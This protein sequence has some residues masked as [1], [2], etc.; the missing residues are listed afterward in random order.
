MK[1]ILLVDFPLFTFRMFHGAPPL[2]TKDGVESGFEYLVLKTL[3]GY[4][5]KY[6]KVYLCLDKGGK[7]RRRKIDSKYK[8]NREEAD[9][10]MFIRLANMMPALEERFTFCV[11]DG[12]EADDV[13]FNLTNKQK[14]NEAMTILSNDKDLFHCLD[15][16]VT[17]EVLGRGQSTIW[18]PQRLLEKFRVH[19]RQWIYFRAFTGDPSDNLTG[20]KM[21]RK[22]LV[23]EAC[24]QELKNPY[25]L[26]PFQN[27]FNVYSYLLRKVSDTMRPRLIVFF[28]SKQPHSNFAVMAPEMGEV[29]FREPKGSGEWDNFLK[30]FE[31]ES[32]KPETEF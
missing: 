31:L 17:Q 27:I 14:S 20:C 28:Q 25:E 6:S 3:D 24:R 11:C 26:T 29:V 2:T 8:D 7:K 16:T 30:M 5:R 18:T 15:E 13:I 4:K 32:L 23:A 21:I 9:E 1:K 10:N 22:N 19:P 12:L